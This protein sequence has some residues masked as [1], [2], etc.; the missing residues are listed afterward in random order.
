[1][2]NELTKEEREMIAEYAPKIGVKALAWAMKRNERTIRNALEE[3]P[4]WTESVEF[5]TLKAAGKVVMMPS[6]EGRARQNTVARNCLTC[7]KFL[8]F[9]GCPDHPV[10]FSGYCSG[11]GYPM[12]G[13]H[14]PGGCEKAAGGA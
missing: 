7:G 2:S 14:W 13:R 1:M 9:N 4:S 10:D 5:R 12:P 11:C 3:Q 6:R 8:D